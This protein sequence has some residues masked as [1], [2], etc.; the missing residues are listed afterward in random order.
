VSADAKRIRRGAAKA[1]PRRVPDPPRR[2]LLVSYASSPITKDVLRRTIE[3]ATPE[4]AKITVLGIAKVF[5]TSLGLPH[6]ALKPNRVEWEDQRNVVQRAADELI[7]RG[8]DVLLASAMARNAPKLIARWVQARNF[9]AVVI[10]DPERPGWRRRIE[11]DLAN[12]IGRRA[13]V[14]V[15]AVPV[16]AAGS[17]NGR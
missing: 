17:K 9:H 4:H 6:P 14:P 15:H 12:E 8:F 3:L 16:P 1:T 5:G 10:P 13:H 11:G 7:G 2:I